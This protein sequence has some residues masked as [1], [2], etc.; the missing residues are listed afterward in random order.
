MVHIPSTPCPLMS[1]WRWCT[2]MHPLLPVPYPV[3]L[4]HPRMRTPSAHSLFVA[5]APGGHSGS[6][7]RTAHISS[8][9]V[10]AL[11]CVI[12]MYARFCCSCPYAHPAHATLFAHGHAFGTGVL[13]YR[14]NPL[15]SSPTSAC[16]RLPA[17]MH[18]LSLCLF[19]HMCMHTP[20]ALGA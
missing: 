19:P 5:R 4:T 13:A 17:Y 18:T 15:P 6:S 12:L 9:G 20:S 3:F 1:G 8:A 7:V 11:P 16:P 14:R 2:A 10:G